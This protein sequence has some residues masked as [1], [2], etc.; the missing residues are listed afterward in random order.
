MTDIPAPFASTLDDLPSDEL[1]ALEERVTAMTSHPAWAEL[2][3][4][5]E[6]GK[7][8]VQY[9]IAHGKTHD[10]AQYARYAGYL[11]GADAT[12]DA[13]R[14]VLETAARRRAHLEAEA[15]REREDKATQQEAEKPWGSQEQEAQPVES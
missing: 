8:T 2:L 11:S 10:H 3:E 9:T 14:A 6:K 1:F 4:L 5:V 15:E 7:A 13:G 12:R